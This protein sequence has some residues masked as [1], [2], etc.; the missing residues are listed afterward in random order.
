MQKWCLGLTVLEPLFRY[1]DHM[2]SLVNK[3]YSCYAL[4]SEDGNEPN[5]SRLSLNKPEAI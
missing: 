2:C 1:N 3:P 4:N 5:D